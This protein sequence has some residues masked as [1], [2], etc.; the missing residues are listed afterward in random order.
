M[1]QVQLIEQHGHAY[2]DLYQGL[3]E[4]IN[5]EESEF[6]EVF[7]GNKEASTSHEL[8]WKRFLDK[9]QYRVKVSSFST[10]PVQQDPDEDM[11]DDEEW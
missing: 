10:P 11:S 3:R 7:K 8:V 4:P 2:S 9:T 5:T 6:I 1:T